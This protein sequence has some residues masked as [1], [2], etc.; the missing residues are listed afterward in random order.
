MRC[1]IPFVLRDNAQILFF[2][3]LVTFSIGYKHGISERV[4]DFE[5]LPVII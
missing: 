5:T 1:S 4:K 3:S 2:K